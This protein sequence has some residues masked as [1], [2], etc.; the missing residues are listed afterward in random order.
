MA[1]GQVWPDP[2]G[3]LWPSHAVSIVRVLKQLG[4]MLD[5]SKNWAA[6]CTLILL[7]IQ[8]CGA[9]STRPPGDTMGYL[10]HVMCDGRWCKVSSKRLLHEQRYREAKVKNI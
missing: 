7:K 2:T 4:F 8:S 3:I 9:R 1:L 6:R 10:G 5:V